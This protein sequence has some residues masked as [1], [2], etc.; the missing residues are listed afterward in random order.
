MKILVAYDGSR[1]ADAAVEEVFRRPWPPGSQVRVL[2]VIEPLEALVTADGASIYVPVIER[3]R[4]SFRE[5]AYERV[6]AVLSR[7]EASD[8]ETSCEVREGGVTAS[9]LEAIREW[10]ADLVVAGTSGKSGAARFFLGS[11]S[12]GLVTHAPCSVEIVRVPVAA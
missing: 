4:A 12:H 11:V 1:A 6:H 8:L 5:K 9:L 10:Q 7:H 3:I 2:T